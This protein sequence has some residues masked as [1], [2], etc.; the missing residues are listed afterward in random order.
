M[1]YKELFGKGIQEKREYQRGQKISNTELFNENDEIKRIKDSI[2][3]AK[4]NQ[5]RAHQIHQNQVKRFQNLI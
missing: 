2:E 4:L 1:I 5:F 3:Q